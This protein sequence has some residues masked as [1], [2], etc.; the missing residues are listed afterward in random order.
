MHLPELSKLYYTIGEVASMFDV[1][2]SVIRY[3]DAE[4]PQL[5]PGKNSKG[6][7]KFT[8]RDIEQIKEIY[9]LVKEK[10]FTI[11]GARRELTI[12]KAEKKNYLKV[13]EKLKSIKEDIQKLKGDLL[14]P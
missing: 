11:D 4:F 8:P 5:K 12:Q 7:R 2:P 13:I 1:A 10:G 14:L 3:W 6:E 9:H